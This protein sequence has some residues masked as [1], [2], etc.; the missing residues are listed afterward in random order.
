MLKFQIKRT[1]RGSLKEGVEE[2]EKGIGKEERLTWAAPGRLLCT[3]KRGR[4][5]R[6]FRR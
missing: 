3:G 1:K 2:E 5:G 6:V 4:G